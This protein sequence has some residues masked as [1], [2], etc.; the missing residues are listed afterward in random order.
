MIRLTTAAD[1]THVSVSLEPN[2]SPLYSFA[3]RYVHLPL[4]A[5]LRTE[6][7]HQGFFKRYDGIPCALYELSVPDRVR[8]AV[9]NDIERM[10]R[11]APSYRF[12]VMGLIFCGLNVPMH[13]RN[14]YFCSEFVGEVLGRN[15]ALRLP[16]KPSLMR[17]QDYAE[18]PELVCLYRG[19]LRSLRSQYLLRNAGRRV[20]GQSDCS[21]V[22]VGRR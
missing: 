20:G 10:M 13:R 5:G 6:S 4:P 2:L 21:S 9:R 3:R 1:Y 17:P 14:R 8:E 22:S 7:L 18:L 15:G 19:D 16:K 11:D 12:S